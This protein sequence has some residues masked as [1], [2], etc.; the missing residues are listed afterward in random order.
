MKQSIF[1]FISTG[2]SLCNLIFLDSII[3][4][5]RNWFNISS[6]PYKSEK[7]RYELILLMQKL[8]I[9]SPSNYNPPLETAIVIFTHA[10]RLEKSP[11]IHLLLEDCFHMINFIMDS[12]IHSQFA[13]NAS[14]AISYSSKSEENISA[15]I[16]P[17]DQLQNQEEKK[18]SKSDLINDSTQ[19]KKIISN[20]RLEATF[21][22]TNKRKHFDT[23]VNVKVAR[24]DESFD[25]DVI[26]EGISKK[27]EKDIVFNN[28]QEKAEIVKT[29]EN[30]VLPTNNKMMTNETF[31]SSVNLTV[32]TEQTNQF[33]EQQLSTE[34]D[35][36]LAYF[37][38]D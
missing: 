8:L 1:Y 36:A 30:I 9:Q 4:F 26:F 23:A 28:N 37:V 22:E 25:D 32:S 34:A 33:K 12:R 14:Q 31:D 6:S 10:R 17:Q 21:L 2:F 7:C 15:L 38:V 20:D 18:L 29:D 5:I 35:E 13:T 24:T 11:S 3:F 16:Y 19:I 27:S